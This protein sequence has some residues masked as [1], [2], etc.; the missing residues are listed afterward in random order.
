[1]CRGVSF[2][3]WKT[4]RGRDPDSLTHSLSQSLSH[5]LTLS[6]QR[7]QEHEQYAVNLHFRHCFNYSGW[8]ISRICCSHRGQRVL[9]LG[10]KVHRAV[11][12]ASFDIF[13]LSHMQ[14]FTLTWPS[15]LGWSSSCN[16]LIHIY[17]YVPSAVYL[18]QG[19]LLTLRS[20]DH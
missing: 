16:V 2:F 10:C 4:R 12:Y 13:S 19:L 1:M 8:L 7:L 14:D 11:L 5:L 3:P 17:L 18:F 6:L 15:G 9:Y 20:N